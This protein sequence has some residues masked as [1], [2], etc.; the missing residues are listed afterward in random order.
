MKKILLGVMASVLVG[1]VAY[2]ATDWSA[3]GLNIAKGK[4]SWA[5][6]GN[7][8][9]GNDGNEG[10]RWESQH[11]A[12][13]WWCVDLGAEY[14]LD[15][16]EIK[17][18]GA[19][20]KTYDLYVLASEPK[21]TE[22]SEAV[23]DPAGEV[24]TFNKLDAGQLGTPFA[25]S[26]DYPVENLYTTISGLENVR[27]RYILIDCHERALPYGISFFEFYVGEKIADANKVTK[28]SVADMKAKAGTP[29][30][31]TVTGLNRVGGEAVANVTGATFKAS[32]PSITVAADGETGYTLT[33]TKF[34]KYTLETTATVEG[35]T[36]TTTSNVEVGPDWTKVRNIASKAEN[37]LAQAYA[38]HNNETAG[39][40]N[41]GNNN[42][43]WAGAP[44]N[45]NDGRCWWY[46]DLGNT[47]A[48]SVAEAEFETAGAKSYDV[49]VATETEEVEGEDGVKTVQPKWGDTPVASASGIPQQ[50]HVVSTLAV[51]NVSARYVKFDFTERNHNYPISPYELRVGGEPDHAEVAA[52]IKIE[53]SALNIA[54]SEQVT[55]KASV[56]GDYGSTIADAEI[57][58]ELS[59]NTSEATL[60]ESNV[61]TTAKKGSVTVTAKSGNIVSEPVVITTVAAG[62]DLADV[63]K[64][65]TAVA[66]DG[67]DASTMID[68]NDGS[69]FIFADG[70]DK[71]QEHTC[72]ID[73]HRLV[74]IDMVRI[75]MEGASS[76]NYTLSFSKD[77]ENYTD[78]YGYEGPDAIDGYTHSYFGKEAKETRYVKFHSTRNGTGYGLKVFEVSVFGD[79]YMEK[80]GNALS[81]DW[82][83]ADF[84][85]QADP[86][87]PYIDVT[88]VNNLPDTKPVVDGA[89]P[90]QLLIVAPG[91]KFAAESN[92]V[93]KGEDET[94][95]AALIDLYNTADFENILNV[96]A[97][98]ANVHVDVPGANKYAEAYL[99]FAYKAAES[100]ELYTFEG[101]DDS[102]NVY[103]SDKL[104]A[105]EPNTPF[106]ILISEDLKT[107]SA[108]DVELTP[109][110]AEAPAAEVEIS[111]VTM[112]GTYAK[113]KPESWN[114]Y[115]VKKG[116]L[117]A[118]LSADYILPF[119]NYTSIDGITR[120]FKIQPK[121][122]SVESILGADANKPV[123]VFTVDGK[124]VKSGVKAC[125]ATLGLERGIYIV[126]GRKMLVTK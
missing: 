10:S 67:I 41:D 7:A 11:F 19:Y 58:Y 98:K 40:A 76:A 97:A 106:L 112:T 32:D 53:A 59:D 100:E 95:S 48:I 20:A 52:S 104:E 50:N 94:L 93:V 87:A 49:Y 36:F 90:N 21:F 107:I 101:I 68:A 77:G 111:P 91:T 80:E 51:N 24:K 89:N 102:G 99:P 26:A 75:H 81:G 71:E 23:S 117:R 123:N 66:N 37:E 3:E 35:E 46:V 109:V 110:A 63:A 14:D 88:A 31:F 64:G 29:C 60:S 62:E 125:E 38:S 69:M 16:I 108:T 61:L 22:V 126:G 82:H 72:V 39:L 12:P 79:T 55:F 9:A 42:T 113:T 13:Q 44:T 4:T 45:D 18:E 114:G 103:L 5:S 65:A 47:Y 17:W 118:V 84:A 57:A 8:G 30:S 120:D 2:A 1:Q 85:A 73:L 105:V 70:G 116:E 27:G 122:L 54:S 6:T 56:V 121:P 124:L 119:G 43:R 15:R 83:A 78:Y 115:I 33:A 86:E 25:T 92:V 28:I 96:K 74:D 34:G